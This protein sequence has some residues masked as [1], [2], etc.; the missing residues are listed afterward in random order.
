MTAKTKATESVEPTT[1]V[2]EDIA[3]FFDT[4]FNATADV[5]L[6][7]WDLLPDINVKAGPGWNDKD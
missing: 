4:C 7:A 3:N 2:C 6:G 5:A 1:T